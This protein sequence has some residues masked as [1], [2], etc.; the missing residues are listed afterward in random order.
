MKLYYLEL[1]LVIFIVIVAISVI[2]F[3]AMTSHEEEMKFDYL[4]TLNQTC[5]FDM[6]STNM[7]IFPPTLMAGRDAT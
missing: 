6:N 1:G 7:T 5:M 4:C 2:M 3:T